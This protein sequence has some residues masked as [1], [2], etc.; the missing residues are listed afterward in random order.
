MSVLTL[1]AGASK[2]FRVTVFSGPIH[3]IGVEFSK[4]ARST[5]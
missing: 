5:G 4:G 2:L 3:S 1:L